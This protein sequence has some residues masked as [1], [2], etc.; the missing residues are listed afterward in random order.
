VLVRFGVFVLRF[1]YLGGFVGIMWRLRFACVC[2]F[3][4]VVLSFRL[5]VVG[6]LTVN[7]VAFKLFC[8]YL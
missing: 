3:P 5:C 6:W 1:D 2:C 4:V 8:F 7:S